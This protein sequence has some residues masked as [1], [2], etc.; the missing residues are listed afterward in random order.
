MELCSNCT[1]EDAQHVAAT[2]D[3]IKWIRNEV[4]PTHRR[5]SR[6]RCHPPKNTDSGRL[7]LRGP[8][9]YFA[10]LSPSFVYTKAVLS[11]LSGAALVF[12][13]SLISLWIFFLTRSLYDHF[14]LCALTEFSLSRF[15]TF[16]LED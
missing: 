12:G 10:T 15:D 8:N 9:A 16:T 4:I 7:S 14:S 3:P 6:P 5:L 11:G 13:S 2:P 1:V